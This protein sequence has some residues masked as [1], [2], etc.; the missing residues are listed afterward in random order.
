MKKGVNIKILFISFLSKFT[1]LFSNLYEQK[2]LKIYDYINIYISILIYMLIY[3]IINQYK[4]K[5]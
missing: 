4:T 5:I 1:T 3:I 2:K